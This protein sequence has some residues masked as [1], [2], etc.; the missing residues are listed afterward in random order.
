VGCQIGDADN[1]SQCGAAGRRQPSRRACAKRGVLAFGDVLRLRNHVRG[2]ALSRAEAHVVRSGNL[3]YDLRTISL[4][5]SEKPA[6]LALAVGTLH[7]QPTP[8]HVQLRRASTATQQPSNSSPS[9][10][11]QRAKH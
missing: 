11:S 2:M 1:C 6:T 8:F 10:S 3:G 5:A 4:A 9:I 7:S